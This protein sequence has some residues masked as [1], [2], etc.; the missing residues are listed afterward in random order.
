[1]NKGLSLAKVYINSSYGISNFVYNLKNNKK[2]AAKAIALVLL[3]LFS[4][5]GLFGMYLYFNIK[6]YDFLKQVQQQGM[7]ITMAVIFASILTVMFGI[8]TVIANYFF[9]QEG[10]VVLALPLSKKDLLL[11]KFI[12]TYIVEAIVTFVIMAI[13]VGVY[14]VK[15]KE[16][17]I[18]YL[19][20]IIA[21]I[22][23]PLIPLAICYFII[24][25]FMNYGNFAKKKDM[26]MI[27][28]G[29]FGIGIGVLYQYFIST[30]VN[31]NATPE[32]LV[33]KLTNKNGLIDVVGRAYYPSIWVSNGVIN[34]NKV[35]GLLYL[36][37]FV[38]LS[39]L[40]VYVLILTT[41]NLYYKSI[42]GS[43]EVTKKN[44]EI[45]T[46]ELKVIFK[47]NGLI[48]AL[49]NR[50]FKL[51]NREPVYFLNGP[52]VIVFLPVIFG[53]MFFTNNKAMEGINTLLINMQNVKLIFIY[54]IIAI[55]MLGSTASIAPTSISREGNGIYVLKSLPISPMDIIKAKFLHA[56]LFGAL[57]AVITCIATIYFKMSFGYI[58]LAFIV[59]NLW[60]FAS[61][62]VGILI[63]LKWPKLNWDNP[64]K[65][66]KQNVNVIVS[67]F[68][69]FAFAALVYF[70]GTK[71]SGTIS[72][73]LLI[74]VPVILF[75]VL[76]LF[77][78]KYINIL[79]S[80]L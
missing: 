7:V 6:M 58:V 21:T 79:Y 20:S 80:T 17:L 23:I 10:D 78:K 64:Q 51:M 68:I 41:S 44:R 9:N 16:G 42:I 71:I 56:A 36:V 72:V 63:E 26:F 18:F 38:L 49:F 43:N 54:S 59:G 53:I 24:I 75:I 14:G 52:L 48:K 69:T 61:Y 46:S 30:L 19:V 11:A 33:N 13:G 5:T 73:I 8:I 34:Y 3:I 22:F 74:A 57:G 50:E 62:L 77:L 45:R 31:I 37:S 1:M 55:I 60:L 47:K 12:N 25:P 4:T 40:V 27:I 35:S 15:S 2:D 32:L 28:G 65:P 29:L 76:Y 67:L 66:M 39:L 70:I